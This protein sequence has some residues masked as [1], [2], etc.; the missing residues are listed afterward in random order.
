M[1]NVGDRFERPLFV[2]DGCTRRQDNAILCERGDT[3]DSSY[4]ITVRFTRVAD[5]V[6]RV[7]RAVTTR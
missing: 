5:E 2:G 6:R 3:D 7:P 4:E 1:P